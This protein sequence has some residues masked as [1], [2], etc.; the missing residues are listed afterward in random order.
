MSVT[1]RQSFVT[2]ERKKS[3]N[4]PGLISYFYVIRFSLRFLFV[5]LLFSLFQGVVVIRL[6][7]LI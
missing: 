3:L 6:L 2:S 4:D 7:E 1:L 5:F